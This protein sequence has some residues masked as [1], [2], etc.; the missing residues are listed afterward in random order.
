MRFRQRDEVEPSLIERGYRV[1]DV[2][3]AP[4]RPRRELVFVTERTT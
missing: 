2:R 1:L 3:E 4:D